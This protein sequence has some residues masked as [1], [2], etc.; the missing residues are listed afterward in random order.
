MKTKIVDFR[1][2][3]RKDEYFVIYEPRVFPADDRFIKKL[4]KTFFIF[5]FEISI[6]INETIC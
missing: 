6:L 1:K 3:G 2:R 5:H 4:Q